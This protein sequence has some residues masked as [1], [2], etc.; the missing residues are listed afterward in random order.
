MKKLIMTPL[1]AIL[2]FA[3]PLYAMA[4]SVQGNQYRTSTGLVSPVE[5]VDI[6]SNYISTIDANLSV[7]NISFDG[8]TYVVDVNDGDGN[9]VAQLNIHKLTGAIRPIF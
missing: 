7:G 2:L 3:L 1:V 4:C 9:L 8:Q 5:A 6:T